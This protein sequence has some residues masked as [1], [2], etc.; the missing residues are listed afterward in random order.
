MAGFYNPQPYGAQANPYA[1]AGMGVSGAY[2][3]QNAP[4]SA[5]PYNYTQ[6]PNYAATQPQIGAQQ[7][8]IQQQMPMNNSSPFIMVSSRE[9]AKDITVSA[10]QTIYA[11]SQNAPEFYVKSADNMGLVTTR[12]FKFAEFDPA[13]EAAQL[14]AQAQAQNN[15]PAGDFVPRSEFN[16]FV[17]NVSQELQNVRQSLANAPQNAVVAEPAQTAKP[18]TKKA[19]EN[20]ND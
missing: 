9:N 3:L 14:Q 11:M 7:Q 8:L 13:V 18:S 6:Q 4:Y 2:G 16:Q 20:P 10:N 19:K 12:Y 15:A 5:N 17:T 1:N